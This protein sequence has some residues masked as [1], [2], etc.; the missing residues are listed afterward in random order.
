MKVKK[1]SQTMKRLRAI[2]KAIRTVLLSL[3]Y[4]DYQIAEESK[5]KVSKKFK[6]AFVVLTI[7]TILWIVFYALRQYFLFLIM[8]ISLS[9]GWL[10]FIVVAIGRMN[11]TKTRG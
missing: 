8:G 3:F 6:L 7:T 10:G 9:A 2:G 11:K 4:M 1:E 5:L